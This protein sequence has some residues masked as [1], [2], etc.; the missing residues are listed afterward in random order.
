[1]IV[2]LLTVIAAICGWLAFL[3]GDRFFYGLIG[4][5]ALMSVAGMFA[6]DPSG[7]VFSSLYLWFLAFVTLGI[8][9]DHLGL[10]VLFFGLILFIAEVIA[11]RYL[12]RARRLRS[13]AA[14]NVH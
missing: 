2:A 11:A 4:F 8:S 7:L 13:A 14:S 10:T 6:S 1:M 12:W 3:S 9:T 5:F